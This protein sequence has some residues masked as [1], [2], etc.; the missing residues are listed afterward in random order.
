MSFKWKR[1]NVSSI[2]IPK[3]SYEDGWIHPLPKIDGWN[4]PAAPVPTRALLGWFTDCL[5]TDTRFVSKCAQ[6][7]IRSVLSLI[8]NKKSPKWLRSDWKT[9]IILTIFIIYQL[10]LTKFIL[11]WSP[12]I[13][14]T[15]WLSWCKNVSLKYVMRIC[16][17]KSWE[18]K[19]HLFIN[20]NYSL[21]ILLCTPLLHCKTE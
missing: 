2:H 21:Q 16:T 12:W 13:F 5:K 8:R 7:F 3:G 20:Q 6:I 14:Y 18:Y 4:P 17:T 11:I 10:N 19:V 15:N 9:R 1:S